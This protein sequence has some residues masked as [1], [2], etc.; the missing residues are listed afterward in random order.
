MT[1]KEYFR[2]KGWWWNAKRN[3]KL[4]FAPLARIWRMHRLHR[5]I[6]VIEKLTAGE[7][8]DT[9]T[10]M[11]HGLFQ[12]LVDFVEGELGY[13]YQTP[14]EIQNLPSKEWHDIHQNKFDWAYASWWDRN[15]RRRRF[16]KE[17]LAIAHL[18]WEIDLI[19][20]AD[21]FER[22]MCQRQSEM[23]KIQKE[24]YLWYKHEYPKRPDP[25]D[26]YDAL[27]KEAYPTEHDG[28]QHNWSIHSFYKAKR[29]E[30]ANAVNDLE[31]KY[32]DEDEAK[33]IQLIKIR[34]SLW[35]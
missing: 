25:H 4:F 8:W 5:N 6:L 20:S 16:W 9:D 24:L 23:A 29:L 14:E 22:E 31:E 34:R 3:T 13:C 35:T 2:T 32:H 10:I 17:K 15:I 18:D 30:W 33:M 19:N 26:V 12:M 11:F 1:T 7:W 28:D 27:Y 21:E